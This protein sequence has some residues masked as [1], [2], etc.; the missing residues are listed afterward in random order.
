MATTRGRPPLS[1][2][3]PDAILRLPVGTAVTLQTSGNQSRVTGRITGSVGDEIT[4]EQ[5]G[6][7]ERV[8]AT[9]DIRRGRVVSA[10]FSDNEG[11]LRV[12]VPAHVW[13]G[14]V[15]RSTGR[16]VQVEQ[17]DG[18]FVWLD[19]VDLERPEDRI[20]ALPELRR[21]PVPKARSA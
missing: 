4:L 20:A 6:G 10:L 5:T 1:W 19:E 7:R 15:V 16:R 2:L 8:I 3:D 13:R 11:V 17:I 12:G 18:T 14:A 21:G 9:R